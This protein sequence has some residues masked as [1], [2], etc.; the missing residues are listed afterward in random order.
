MN[1]K[2]MWAAVKTLVMLHKMEKEWPVTVMVLS[3][4][5]GLS[6]SYIEQIFSLLKK[7]GMVV[8]TKGPG[9]GYVPSERKVS[10]ADI[11]LATQRIPDDALFGPVML[12]LENV[13]L[14]T[15]LSVTE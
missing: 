14:D 7:A 12:A 1:S 8:S 2:K 10:V 3:E 4:K 5:T 15:L 13:S 11:L 9:G 6:C